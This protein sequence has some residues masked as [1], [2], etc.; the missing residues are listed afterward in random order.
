MVYFS[1]IYVGVCIKLIKTGWFSF[2]QN[3]KYIVSGMQDDINFRQMYWLL[4]DQTSLLCVA[5]FQSLFKATN[6]Y[7]NLSGYLWYEDIRA[8]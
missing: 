2:Y 1:V 8:C 4:S 6:H 7:I 3:E 5:V